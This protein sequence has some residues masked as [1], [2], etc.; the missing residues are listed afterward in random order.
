MYSNS[1]ARVCDARVQSSKREENL[2][3]NIFMNFLNNIKD[4]NND[5]NNYNSSINTFIITHSVKIGICNIF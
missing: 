5:N 2:S 3:W 1:A 4:N